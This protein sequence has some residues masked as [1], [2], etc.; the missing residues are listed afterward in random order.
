MRRDEKRPGLDLVLTTPLWKPLGVYGYWDEDGWSGTGN[1]WRLV[2]YR[3]VFLLPA[4]YPDTAITR[5][6]IWPTNSLTHSLTHSLDENTFHCCTQSCPGQSTQHTQRSSALE[7]LAEWRSATYGWLVDFCSTARHCTLVQ[8]GTTALHRLHWL[9]WLHYTAQWWLHINNT[10]CAMYIS[11]PLSSSVP[12]DSSSLDTALSSLL[13][14]ILR[15][16]SAVQ[17]SAVQVA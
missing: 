2:S 9:H 4:F 10:T 8:K 15:V 11:S 16:R 3:A 17:C 12:N 6:E 5:R 14:I 13:P 7:L 1:A